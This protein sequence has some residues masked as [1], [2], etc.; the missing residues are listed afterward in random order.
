[1]M[2]GSMP[3]TALRRLRVQSADGEVEEWPLTQQAAID[4]TTRRRP[5]LQASTFVFRRLRSQPAWSPALA[6]GPIAELADALEDAF[7]AIDREVRAL[8]APLLGDDDA[9]DASDAGDASGSGGA[10]AAQSEGLHAGVWQRLELYARGAR[11]AENCARLPALSAVLDASAAV[12]RD[13][14]G[15]CYVSLMTDGTRVEEH[16]GPT[17]HRLRLHLPVVLPTL[18]PAARGQLGI[19]VGGELLRWQVGRCLL[20]DDSY[21]HSVEL[22]PRHAGGASW[23][24]AVV[25]IDVWHPDA[26]W[27]VPLSE[28]ARAPSARRLLCAGTV[29]HA[30]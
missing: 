8:L 11:Q 30:T 12:M 9:S 13:A 10:W 25:V 24:R 5:P 17:N 15:R 6:G 26:E 22:P 1:M 27:L 3:G 21:L 19:R 20:F 14:P 29:S 28:R 2:S 4:A 7:G 16:C 23:V 18:P